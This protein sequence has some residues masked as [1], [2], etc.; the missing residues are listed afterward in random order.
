MGPKQ[1]ELQAEERSEAVGE[2]GEEEVS[3][4]VDND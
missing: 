4:T 2:E 1:V 3:T